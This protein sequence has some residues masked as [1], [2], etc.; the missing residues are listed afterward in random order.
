[1]QFYTNQTLN[2]GNTF[3]IKFKVHL[4]IGIPEVLALG[5]LSTIS[6]LGPITADRGGYKLF[7]Y[8]LAILWHI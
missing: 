3:R 7:T 8:V 2:D 6:G 4:N 1:M 5:Y